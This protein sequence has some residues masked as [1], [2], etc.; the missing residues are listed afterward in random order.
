MPNQDKF[1]DYDSYVNSV[2]FSPDGKTLVS[3]SL[4][5]TIKLWNSI[6]SGFD[7]LRTI[8]SHIP[9]GSGVS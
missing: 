9:V 8:H 6:L 4:D 5:K 2:N 1:P 7:I 3:G